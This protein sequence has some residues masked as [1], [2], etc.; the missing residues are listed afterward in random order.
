MALNTEYGNPNWAD[1][2]TGFDTSFKEDPNKAYKQAMWGPGFQQNQDWIKKTYF[3]GDETRFADWAAGGN[4]GYTPSAQG[5]YDPQFKD[6][7]QII[8]DAAAGKVDPLYQ[9][10]YTPGGRN[11][12]APQ[13]RLVPPGDLSTI[14]GNSTYGGGNR[15]NSWEGTEANPTA[16]T[17]NSWVGY[18]PEG[19][20]VEHT[21]INS[22]WAAPQQPIINNKNMNPWLS[23]LY[24][25]RRRYGP[26]SR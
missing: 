11:T 22:P 20:P 9:P 17:N 14:T 18:G 15:N 25:K 10:G 23:R 13:N 26:V 3:G 2:K 21:S 19:P 12:A 5:S 4:Y 6:M 16:S 1:F 24:N 8:Q 7:M